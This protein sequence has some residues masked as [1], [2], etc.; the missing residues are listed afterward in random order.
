MCRSAFHF[1]FNREIG[2]ISQMC[3]TTNKNVTQQ[4]YFYEYRITYEDEGDEE[5]FFFEYKSKRLACF[6]LK[7][8]VVW[9]L[10]YELW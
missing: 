3:D 2:M 7:R 8:D 9:F 5:S 4:R 1:L 10:I 6:S